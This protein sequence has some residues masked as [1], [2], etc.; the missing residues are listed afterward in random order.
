MLKSRNVDPQI[1]N[2]TLEKVKQV[3]FEELGE[4]IL[5]RKQIIDALGKALEDDTK[6]EDYVHNLIM[7][8]K[9]SSDDSIPAV[10]KGYLT[11]LWLLDDKYM[12]YSFAASDKTMKQITE[13]VMQ[14]YA[15]YKVKDRPDI[16]IFFNKDANQ[17]DAV[18]CELKGAKATA[19]EKDKS[20][21]ELPNNISTIRKNIQECNRIWG[22]IITEIDDEFKESLN[23]Q[24][25]KPLFTNDENGGLY[26]KYFANTDAFITVLDLQT[27]ISDA[28]AR[29]KLFLDILAQ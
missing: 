27:L 21:T 9:S 8:M 11:N 29:N 28:N 24:D 13:A 12:T 18:V 1:F 7:P 15:K 22:Y 2:S 17:K 3:A 10:K 4:Y 20:L 23:T 26:F 14:N 6:K 25:Y 16:T 5:Y 19:D